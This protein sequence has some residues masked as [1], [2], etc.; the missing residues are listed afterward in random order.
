LIYYDQQTSEFSEPTVLTMPK[1]STLADL[2]K[3]LNQK[4]NIPENQMRLIRDTNSI[5][6]TPKIME[7]DNDGLREIHRV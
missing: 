2:K 3:I 1:D 6:G 4:Y 5:N 7:G